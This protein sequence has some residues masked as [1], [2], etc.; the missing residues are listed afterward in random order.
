MIKK[1]LCLI[2]L[3]GSIQIA[4]SQDSTAYSD[5]NAFSED[6]VSFYPNP[7]QDQIKVTNVSGEV[8]QFSV[9]NILG[10]EVLKAQLTK[11]ETELSLSQLT[12]GV[13]IVA[14]Y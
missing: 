14:F 6:Q 11:V 2:V 4:V 12:S 5:V 10:D 8:V 1:L 3:L 13:Y 9:Y 7:S